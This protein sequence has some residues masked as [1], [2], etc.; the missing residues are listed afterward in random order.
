MIKEVINHEKSYDS[1]PN[2]TA[3]DCVRIIGIGRNQF[4]NTVNNYKSNGGETS[5]GWLSRKIKKKS[6]LSF[7]PDKPQPVNVQH[8][9]V[10]N[11]GVIKEDVA[12]THREK[13]VVE[14]L[15]IEG[16]KEAGTIAKQDLNSLHEKGIIYFTVPISSNDYIT[17]PPLK[18]FVMNRVSGDYFE[19]LLYTLFIT[20]DQRTNIETVSR[21]LNY[22]S[23][24]VKQA[25]SMYIR[26]GF[27]YKKSIQPI[28]G[29]IYEVD[30]DKWHQDWIDEAQEVLQGIREAPEEYNSSPVI[31]TR[32]TQPS[33][34]SSVE[35]VYQKRI[36]FL[37]DKTLTAYLMM[38]NLASSGLQTHAVNL[39]EV[40]KL[41]NER[42]DDFLVALDLVSEVDV[43][44]EG[45]AG[46]YFEHAITLRNTIRFLRKC[47]I[48]D[49]DGGVD[50][51]RAERLNSIPHKSKL[52]ILNRSYAVLISMAPLSC[53][54]ITI[55]SGI[56]R[57][58]GP[59]I[60]EVN[61]IWFKMYLYHL[62]QLG[63]DCTFYPKGTRITQIPE[64]FQDCETLEIETYQQETISINISNFLTAVNDALTKSPVLVQGRTYTEGEPQEVV[65]P[66]PIDEKLD[67]EE[68]ID[69]RHITKE[70]ILSHPVIKSLKENFYLQNSF[71]YVKMLLIDNPERDIYRW[72]VQDIYYGIPLSEMSLNTEVCE[73]IS[74]Y[75]LFSEKNQ[76]IYSQKSRK[77]SIDLLD[78]IS[79]SK[80]NT[81]PIETHTF[82]FPNKELNWINA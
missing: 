27:A 3:A 62:L 8:W 22:D 74:Q 13:A 38:A 26:L 51:I 69:D 20:V 41:E 50:L 4:I 19:N 72:V 6:I 57:H 37:F 63:P 67:M 77:L 53:E 7:L 47:D 44:G 42:I 2:F 68:Y 70:N 25:V 18:D 46:R 1:L 12:L 78:Y 39:Y 81:S 23:A 9:W 35:D 30:P 59:V 61:S 33:S 29:E 49:T 5:R 40:G 80:D 64:H 82:P 54:D 58:F 17:I 76:E 28:L 31:S 66:F 16:S 79:L 48:I 10:V 11:L 71:G 60:P 14:S 24:L 32:F 45:E 55:S 36:G 65:V 15:K 43:L 52:N 21:L 34:P 73:K 75:N 56:P